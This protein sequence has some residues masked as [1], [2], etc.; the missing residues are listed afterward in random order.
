MQS[1]W[2]YVDP[3]LGSSTGAGSTIREDTDGDQQLILK[4]DRVVNFIGGNN[5]SVF[6]DADGD[7]KSD[8]GVKNTVSVDALKTL[9]RA[10]T[11]LW[12][13]SAA[14]RTIYTQTNGAT[15]T[16]FASLGSDPNAVQLLQA[17]NASEVPQ[18][19]SYV[20]GTDSA[21][22]YRN[23]TLTIP[24]GIIPGI[25]AQASNVWKLGD[26]ISSTPKVQSQVPLGSYN[27]SAPSGYADGTYANFIGSHDMVMHG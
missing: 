21:H 9:W 5:A 25:A 8:D 7:G 18:I 12:Q 13:Q 3:F 16:N 14:G 1:L 20:T 23:R 2:Y 6:W 11:A 19:I 10:G 22:T 26:I 24:A 17:K 15:L 4:N 27:L